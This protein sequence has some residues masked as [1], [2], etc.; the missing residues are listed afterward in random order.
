MLVTHGALMCPEQPSLEQRNNAM[1]ARQQFV[2]DFLLAS[3]ALWLI[4]PLATAPLAL[5]WN[6]HR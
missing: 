5:C 2:V 3:G 6:R 4:T 1:R